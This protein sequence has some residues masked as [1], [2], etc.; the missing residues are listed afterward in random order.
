MSNYLL[1]ENLTSTICVYMV[2]KKLLLPWEQWDACKLKIIDKTGK[3][4]R[5]PV[6]A[7]E[8]EAWDMLTRLCWNLKKISDKFIGKSKFAT[9]FTAS[10][11]LKDSLN[12]YITINQ[13][14]LDESLLSDMTFKTQSLL[15]TILKEL[16]KHENIVIA[17]HENIDG[18]E[19]EMHKS[20]RAIEEVLILHPEL[21]DLFEDETAGA[22]VA[23][24]IAQQAQ[25][26]GLK[27]RENP[28]KLIKP[29]VEKKPKR[30]RKRK[31]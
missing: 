2:L 25:Y 15:Y 22:T 20:L 13:K 3:K 17:I 6:T 14:R 11:L 21:F 4:L 16:P 24:D 26:L 7:K 28:S 1:S 8:R 30:K 10:Y 5:H 23:A 29:A 19:I 27:K 12:S 31:L 9:Y 18:I